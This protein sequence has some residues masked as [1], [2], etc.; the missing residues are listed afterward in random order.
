MGFTWDLHLHFKGSLLSDLT[1]LV[2]RV[3]TGRPVIQ[4]ARQEMTVAFGFGWWGEMWMDL[5]CI[6]EMETTSFKIN[7]R[8]RVSDRM[9]SFMTSSSPA[10]AARWIEVCAIN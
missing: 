7:W 1:C 8:G 10:Y 5:R 9:E 3:D 6:S 4:M 2:T